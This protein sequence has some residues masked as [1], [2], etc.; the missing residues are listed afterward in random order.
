MRS[1]EQVAEMLPCGVGEGG[2]VPLARRRQNSNTCSQVS[3]PPDTILDAM[4]HTTFR[5]ALAPTPAQTAMLARHAGASRFAYNQCLRLVTDALAA[6]RAGSEAKVPWSGFDLIN[7]FNAW[8][9]G[10]A[11]GRVFVAAPDGTITKQVTGLGWRH[12]VSAQVFE[13]AAVDLGRALSAYGQAKSASRK[14]RR[15]GFPRWK[16]KGR[17]RDSFRL[18][19]KHGKGGAFLIRVGE[20]HPRSV[21]LPTIGAI[22]VHDNTRGLRRLLRP[23]AHFDPNTGQPVVAPRGKVLFATVSRHG[24]RWY[25]S[26]NVRAPNLHA[27]RRHPPRSA[28][29]DAGFV[30]V[31]RG[32]AAFA[33]AATSDGTEVGRFEA[34]KPLQRGIVRLRRLSRRASLTQPRSSRRARATRRLSRQHARIAD[35][36]RNFLHEVSS[37]LVQTH[38]RLC[39]EDLTVANLMTNRRLARAI[40]DAAWTELARQFTY[41]AAWLGAELVV[42]DRWFASTKSC[43]RCGVVKQ[44]LGLAERIFRCAGCGLVIDRD[45][46]AAA[47]LAAWAERSHAQA[48]DRQA[49]GRVI[50]APGGE[51]AGR[52]LGEGGTSPSEGGTDAHAFGSVS[53]DTREGCCRTTSS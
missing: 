17:C 25:V 46:N 12:E 40:G 38:D 16:R 27:T 36:R 7:A 43:S 31:D 52:R 34:P 23:I 50:N 33:V 42:C 5:F 35:V 24:S 39:L 29:D 18:R 2:R 41:K 6:K 22:R 14:G 26:L 30:G 44:Q 4:R 3:H 49:G 21:T 11:A 10:E 19:N 53:L 13:E 37:Q 20:G 1:D 45:R 15:A 32:L 47:N 48:P 28:D 9:R 8:K 51:G